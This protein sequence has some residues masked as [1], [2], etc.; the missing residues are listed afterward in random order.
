[1]RLTEL[2]E[3]KKKKNSFVK[4]FGHVKGQILVP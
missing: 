1:M 3:T 2:K 4:V